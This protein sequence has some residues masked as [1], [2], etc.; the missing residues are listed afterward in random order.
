MSWWTEAPADVGEKDPICRENITMRSSPVA[1][2][3]SATGTKEGE[4]HGN[5]GEGGL[6][7]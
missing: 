2:R 6:S 3:G 4:H 1:D 5:D 7:Y